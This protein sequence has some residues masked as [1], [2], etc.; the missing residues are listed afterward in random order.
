MIRASKRTK[1][2]RKKIPKLKTHVRLARR[3]MWNQ[4]LTAASILSVF[5]SLLL[6]FLGVSLFIHSI[7]V[8]VSLIIGLF[9]P[10]K[11][12]LDWSQKY[13]AKNIGLSYQTALENSE[14]LPYGFQ[15]SLASYI[16]QVLIKLEPPKFRRWWLPILVVSFGF[17]LLPVSPFRAA[18]RTLGLPFGE[19]L[20]SEEAREQQQRTEQA[21]E[22]RTEE[23]QNPEGA[24]AKEVTSQQTNNPQTLEDTAGASGQSLS[25]L[26]ENVA[27]EE[28]LSRFLDNLSE[29]EIPPEQEN[30]QENQPNVQ[31]SSADGSPEEG[32]PETESTQN[33]Q[34]SEGGS[35]GNGDEQQSEANGEQ[36]EQN[37]SQGE[38]Q[39]EDEGSDSSAETGDSDETQSDQEGASS[40]GEQS[41]TNGPTE[42]SSDE[43]VDQGSDGAGENASIAQTSTSLEEDAPTDD[44]EFLQGEL[45]QG[46]SNLAGTVRLPGASEENFNPTGLA[47]PDFQRAQEQAVTEGRIPIE[48]QEIIRNYFR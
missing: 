30:Q 8:F 35:Q 32:N 10:I 19:T 4:K 43:S 46:D 18:P 9:F 3:K 27:D 29:R 15:E 33:S 41:D 24:E 20:S 42:N 21:Q 5:V 47:S 25:D 40:T 34:P 28:A 13:I 44:P 12:S 16:K 14:E 38:G 26:S 22:T 7:G 31:P 23:P 6:W 11:K 17:V 37:E 2:R 45:S 39:G 36:E 48:Y 1:Q